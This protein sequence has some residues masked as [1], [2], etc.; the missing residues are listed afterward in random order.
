MEHFNVELKAKCKNP[1]EI[2]IILLNKGA[3]YIGT[4]HQID[5]Y[6]EVPNGKLKIRRGNIENALVFYERIE[7]PDKRESSIILEL[8]PSQNLE[9][10]LELSLGKKN[11]VNKIRQIYFIGNVKFHIDQ[12]QG[13][14]D[15]VEI[16]AIS[17]NGKIPKRKLEEQFEYYKKLLNIRKKD[18]IN[19]SY[20]EMVK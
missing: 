11:V 8:N 10:I 15:F 18:L 16:E 20:C 1:E 6:Y 19:K 14:G 9:K 12:I 4:D 7:N 2:K 13:I 17:A 5:T 3:K